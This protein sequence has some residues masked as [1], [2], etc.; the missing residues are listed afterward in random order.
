MSVYEQANKSFV[1]L[2][3]PIRVAFR[4]YWRL[5]WAPAITVFALVML[6]ALRLPSY[7]LAD[8]LIFIQPQKVNTKLLDAPPKEEQSERLDSLIYEILSRARL[9][10]IMEQ[11]NLYPELRGVIGKEKAL[12]RFRTAI[13]ITP[14]VSKTSKDNLVQTFRLEFSHHLPKVAFD[15]TKAIA[16]LFIEESILTTKTETQGT[17]E[18]LDTQLSAARKKLEATEAQVQKFVQDNFGKLPEHLQSSVARLERAQ[19]QLA[20]NTQLI[21]ANVARISSLQTELKLAEKDSQ[22]VATG[23][24]TTNASDPREGIAQLESA[25][26]V[27]RT[28]Y[29]DAHP[30]VVG[31]KKQLESLRQRVRSGG[32]P[33]RTEEAPKGSTPESRAVRREIGEVE[34]QLLSLKEEN[35]NLKRQINELESDIKLMPLKE[36][37]LI[38]I[39][40]DYANVRANY[41]NL[42]AAREQAAMQTNLVSSQ[43]G[44]QFRIVEPPSLPS[45]P[46]GPPRLIIAAIGAI[47]GLCCFGAI[48]L[49]FF[50]LTG[51]YKFRD[52]LEEELGI[53]VIGV[54][55]PLETIRSRG[56]VRRAMTFSLITSATLF[57]MGSVGV[58]LTM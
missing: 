18:F 35:V 10:T 40:R 20:T 12:E 44:T 17:E 23:S 3:L 26:A 49:L 57:I 43:K 36:Q 16:N 54:I 15:V 53:P 7:Y 25:L 1:E 22:P 37:E 6:V 55:P 42:S 11:F 27:L 21:T 30:D 39:R 34:A 33:K 29:A 2:I 46:A 9:R 51:A 31:V 8:S 14:V 32:A 4:R 58:F 52:E 13:Q 38:R 48:P 19:S 5:S 41:E 45:L 47:A 50:Y 28:K 24:I 56:V